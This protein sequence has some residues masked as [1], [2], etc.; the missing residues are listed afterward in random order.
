M[1]FENV[2]KTLNKV[3]KI[4]KLNEVE[5]KTILTF[6]R[7]KKEKLEVEGETYDAWRIVHNDSLGPGKGGI[8]F[9]PN[10]SEDEV[11]SLAFWMSM[12]NSLAGKREARSSNDNRQ[13]A[14][15]WWMQI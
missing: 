9:H 1:V 12:K 10:V 6:K 2:S 14:F 11:K 3:S 8:R 5:M 7:I 15:S 13:T 4:M